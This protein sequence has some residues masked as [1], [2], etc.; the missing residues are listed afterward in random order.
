MYKVYIP[1][2]VNICEYG[3]FQSLLLLNKKYYIS[4]TVK[5]FSE[6]VRD[7]ISWKILSRSRDPQGQFQ[8]Q[9]LGQKVKVPKHTPIFEMR[10]DL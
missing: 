8:G 2:I 4:E 5:C 9:I 7:Y 3:Y 1:F 10:A 6:H